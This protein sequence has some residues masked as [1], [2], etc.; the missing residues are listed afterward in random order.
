MSLIF[1]TNKMRFITLMYFYTERIDTCNAC[2]FNKHIVD[3]NINDRPNR[4]G[5]LIK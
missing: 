1:N 4:F 3:F 5:L 2:S